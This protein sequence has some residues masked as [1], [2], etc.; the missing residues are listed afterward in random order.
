MNVAQTSLGL[1]TVAGKALMSD[2]TRATTFA[3]VTT[4]ELADVVPGVTSPKPQVM[5]LRL[6]PIASPG[7]FVTVAPGAL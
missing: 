2:V 3:L 6:A 4:R 5:T 1:G 7:G